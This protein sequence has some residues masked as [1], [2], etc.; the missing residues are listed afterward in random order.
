METIERSDVKPGIK[1]IRYSPGTL[2]DFGIDLFNLQHHILFL[3]EG[4]INPLG[5]LAS[6]PFEDLHESLWDLE[7][8]VNFFS[9]ESGCNFGVNLANDDIMTFVE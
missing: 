2:L 3:T 4:I 5:L 6:I 1:R 9:T 7:E 8:R